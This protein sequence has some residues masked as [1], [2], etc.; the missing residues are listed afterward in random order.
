MSVCWCFPMLVDDRDCVRVRNPVPGWKLLHWGYLRNGKRYN[1]NSKTYHHISTQ[2]TQC[3]HFLMVSCPPQMET[4]MENQLQ[5]EMTFIGIGQLVG[6]GPIVCIH[7]NVVISFWIL[8]ISLFSPDI[9]FSSDFSNWKT[10]FP[11]QLS[12]TCCQQV[13]L[14]RLKCSQNNVESIIML[15]DFEDPTV[16]VCSL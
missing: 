11:M 2:W 9:F 7:E 15:W 16:D 8:M 5:I 10:Y 1:Q 4:V 13:C 3:W 6:T 12:F 14:Q